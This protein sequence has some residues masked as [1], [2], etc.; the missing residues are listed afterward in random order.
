MGGAGGEVE[1]VVIKTLDAIH[2]S[3]GQSF[4]YWMSNGAP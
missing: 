3:R 4:H 1:E 2:L